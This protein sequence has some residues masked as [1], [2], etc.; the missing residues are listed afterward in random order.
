MTETALFT[1]RVVRHSANDT[2]YRLV[3][4]HAEEGQ[5][6]TE[7][8]TVAAL[9]GSKATFE[10]T[11]PV[12][13]HIHFTAAPG[14]QLAVGASLAQISASADRPVLSPEPSLS[15]GASCRFSAKAR[16]L[17]AR[18]NLREEDFAGLELVTEADVRKRLSPSVPAA[19]LRSGQGLK[20]VALIGGGRGADLVIDILMASGR[21]IPVCVYDDHKS[22][23][24]SPLLPLPVRGPADPQQIAR[25]F[26][27]GAF[28][29]AIITI[30]S[31]IAL[32]SRL[33]EALTERGVP[34][35]N[36]VHP[37]ANLAGGASLGQGNV[38]CAFTNIGVCTQIGANNVLSTYCN[39]DHHSVMGSHCTFGPGVMLSGSVTIGSRVRFG[40][41]IFVEPNLSIGDDAVINSGAIIFG[42]IP[43]GGLVKTRAAPTKR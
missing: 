2:D 33:F 38:I 34:L 7:G 42:D 1:L 10:I 19:P 13:G 31:N 16:D 5:F 36:A 11:A 12:A 43:A 35:T 14:D 4:L 18:H 39:I 17:A 20:R 27:N 15:P 22:L 9:E 30:G 40:T 6:V 29:A 3:M 26:Q 32:R 23:F 21:Q 37:L 28:D 24:D 25:D 41:G 8:A